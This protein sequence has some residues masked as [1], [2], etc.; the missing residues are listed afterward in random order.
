MK[1]FLIF[2]GKI[3]IFCGI[4]NI[5]VQKNFAYVQVYHIPSHLQ[6]YD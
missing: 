2:F 3:A 1:S 4:L 5:F 6:F